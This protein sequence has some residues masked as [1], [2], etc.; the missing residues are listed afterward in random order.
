MLDGKSDS[1]VRAVLVISHWDC[2]PIVSLGSVYCI[3]RG[4]GHQLGKCLDNVFSIDK[5]HRTTAWVLLV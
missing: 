3:L 5:D 1:L 4:A 2:Y